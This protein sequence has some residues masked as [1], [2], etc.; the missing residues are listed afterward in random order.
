MRALGWSLF[1]ATCIVFALQGLFLAA[2]T[3]SMT[4][5]EV[6]VDHVFP[7]LGIGAVVGAGVGALIV[8]RY[9]RNLVG[10]LFL[11]GQLG[12]V[13]G[14][15]ADAFGMLVAQGVV[16]SSADGHI[17]G[18]LNQVFGTV[19]TVN[20]MSVT[21]MI[22]P[23]GHLLSRR[24]RFAVS[25]PLAAQALWWLG[26]LAAPE[27]VSLPG[28]VADGGGRE[29]LASALIGA[30][31]FGTLLSILLG[32]VALLLRLRRSTGQQRLQLRWIATGAAVLAV[33]F[34]LFALSSLLPKGAPWIFPEATC[35]AYIFFSVSVGVAIFRYRLYDI[36][37]ILSRAIVLGVLAAFV[38]I[39][40]IAVVVAIGAV[41]QAIGA[42]GS[43]LYWPSLVA[44]ALVA[45]AFQPLR[46][47]VL[48][49]ADELVYGSRAA[50]YEALATLSRQLA[51][52]PSPDALPA[53]VAEAT[54]RAIG[55]AGIT[56][57]LGTTGKSSQ[58][59]SA[60]WSTTGAAPGPTPV[61]VPPLVF[62]VLDM[63][64]QVG[65][66][67]VTPPAG[68][69]LR[70]FERQLLQDVAAQAGIAFRNALLEAELTARVEQ[71]EAQSAEL[72]ASRRRLLGIED[73]ARERLA[74]AIQRRVIPHLAAIDAELTA[75]P[76]EHFA[77]EQLEPLIGE[78]ER[79]LEELRT[80]CRGVFP[81][82]LDRRGLAPALSAQLDLT[83][84]HTLL[85]VDD[86]AKVRLD[87]AVEAAGYLF[88]VEVAP[89]DRSSVI[90]VRVDDDHLLAAVRGDT[91]WAAEFGHTDGTAAPVAWQHPRDRVAALDGAVTVDRNGSGM[92][93]TA[94]IPLRPLDFAGS[95]AGVL[96]ADQLG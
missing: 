14:L 78:T 53:R 3:L 13:I 60:A 88:C 62:P 4:S 82:L 19:F 70:P 68:R 69:A 35:L 66:I 56:V 26:I 20:T 30:G 38:T 21:F 33:T 24:W 7:L 93:V 83:H 2:S 54:G 59:R 55:V 75:G 89:T 92:T 48:R 18:Y 51:D 67:E 22:A 17:A 58:L 40:Y 28:P 42:P 95:A 1:A 52:S 49:L 79:A 37:V 11:I 65:S 73:E 61:G 31:F 86:S 9:P 96:P 39:G 12:N 87:P 74:D 47:H 10:W 50:P 94:T 84:P 64:E 44:T 81:A 5:Y 45:V 8:S 63:G 6:L 76:T 36:D 57:R 90:S 29:T 15:A 27:R 77:P 85:D 91:D 71:G 72:A 80:V 32:A 34:V 43:S 25:V 23:D 41:L 16:D 46:R